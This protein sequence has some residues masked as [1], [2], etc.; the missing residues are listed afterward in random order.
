V[1]ILAAVARPAP[2]QLGCSGATCTVEITMPVVDVLRLSLSVPGISLGSPSEADF[3]AGHKDVIGPG[4]TATVKAN[5]AFQ[6]QVGGSTGTF[7][8]AGSAPDPAKPASDLLWST[9]QAGLPATSTHM[10]MTSMLLNQGTGGS[11]QATIYMRTLWSFLRDVP[12]NYSMS[13][14]LTLSAP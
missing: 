13:V 4:V 12:G 5:R 2:A 14:R 1:A 10:G 6:V 11:V 9:S 3:A 8:Y 7:Q